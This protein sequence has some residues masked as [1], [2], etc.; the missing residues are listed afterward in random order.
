MKVFLKKEKSIQA[1]FCVPNEF[2]KC[3]NVEREESDCTF[4]KG[5]EAPE[6]YS[7]LLSFSLFVR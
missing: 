4:Y 3:F 7:I 1:T 5:E 6:F 2:Y